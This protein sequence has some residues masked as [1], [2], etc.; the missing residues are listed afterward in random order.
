MIF[1]YSCLE[2]VDV[3]NESIGDVSLPAG[4]PVRLKVEGKDEAVT[5]DDPA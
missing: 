3:Y 1:V 5:L 2:P 4:L